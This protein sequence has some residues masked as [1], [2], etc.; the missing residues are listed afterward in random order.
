MKKFKAYIDQDH[1]FWGV[2]YVLIN[3]KYITINLDEEKRQLL[4]RREIEILMQKYLDEEQILGK[5]GEAHEYMPG[6]W[7][8]QFS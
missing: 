5:V 7:S 6:Y 2:V 4:G 3:E 1:S 8:A